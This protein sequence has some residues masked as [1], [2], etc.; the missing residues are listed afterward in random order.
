MDE[1]VKKKVECFR[2][3][4]FALIERM[5]L[6]A[7]AIATSDPLEADIMDTAFSIRSTGTVDAAI[8]EFDGEQWQ[9]ADSMEVLEGDTVWHHTLKNAQFRLRLENKSERD[10]V[11]SINVNLPC[12]VEVED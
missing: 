10:A 4:V 9:V 11:V 5:T 2:P 3:Q 1:Y 6:A 7:G 12:A 8:E